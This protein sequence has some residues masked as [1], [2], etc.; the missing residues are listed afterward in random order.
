MDKISMRLGNIPFL[1]ADVPR[2]SHNLKKN[3]KA[4]IF[5]QKLQKTRLKF[6]HNFRLFLSFTVTWIIECAGFINFTWVLSNVYGN[7]LINV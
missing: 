4:P 5:V 1:T 6:S 2:R 7:A 3:D